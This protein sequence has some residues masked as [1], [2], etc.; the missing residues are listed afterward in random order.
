M[1]VKCVREGVLEAVVMGGLG[2]R[3]WVREK[4]DKGDIWRKCVLKS[5]EGDG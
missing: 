1:K 4:K 5:T 3:R 2:E